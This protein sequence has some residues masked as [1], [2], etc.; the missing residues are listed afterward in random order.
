MH[1]SGTASCPEFTPNSFKR[2]VCQ[3][4]QNK[5]QAHSAAAKEHINAAIEYAADR[6][7]W[8]FIFS[9]KCSISQ[10]VV[11]ISCGMKP[12]SPRQT[13]VTRPSGLIATHVIDPCLR[14]T[15]SQASGSSWSARQT[16]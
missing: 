3:T 1:F 7:S 9:C 12:A 11:S 13:R 5:I 2:D 10:L 14:L 15:R 16:K 4:C 8:N 6:G